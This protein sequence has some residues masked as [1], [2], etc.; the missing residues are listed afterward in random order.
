MTDAL[1]WTWVAQ[2]AMLILTVTGGLALVVWLWTRQRP[3]TVHV[4]KHE[5]NKSWEELRAEIEARQPT[6]PQYVYTDTAKDRLD[7][8]GV[9]R[10]PQP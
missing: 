8:Q 10:G 3:L 7:E 1:S 5:V 2:V 9:K 4:L 6:P